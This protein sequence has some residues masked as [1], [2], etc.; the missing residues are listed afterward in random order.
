MKKVLMLSF[1]TLSSCVTS[2]EFIQTRRAENYPQK[3]I[4]SAQASANNKPS[5]APAVS[6]VKNTIQTGSSKVETET[7]TPLSSAAVIPV[8]TVVLPAQ[9]VTT[10]NQTAPV[11]SFFGQPTKE[12]QKLKSTDSYPVDSKKIGAI[13]PLTGKNA[14]V[15]Q[16]AL[17]ALRLGLGLNESNPSLS[18]ALYDSQGKPELAAAGVQKLLKE[19]GVI[20]IFGGLGAKEALAIAEKSDFYEVPFFSFSQKSGL[21]ESFDYTFRNAV[22]A[23]MQVDKLAEFAFQ[24]LSIR[25]FAI[26]YPNDAYGVEF[27][28]KFWDQVLARG[29]VVAAA[30]VYDPKSSDLNGPVQKMVGTFYNEDRPDEVKAKLKGLKEKKAKQAAAGIKKNSRE[31]EVAENILEPIVDFDAIFIPDSGRALGQAMAFLKSNDIQ[32]LTYLGTNLWNTPDLIRRAGTHNQHLF[33]VDTE[34]S[35]TENTD[36]DFYKKYFALNQEEPQLLEAQTY[37]AA[38]IVR[39]QISMGATGR[40]SLTA[41]LRSLGRRNGAYSE[42][43]MNNNKELERDLTIL[44]VDQGSLKKY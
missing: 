42:I 4:P 20:A 27:A 10:T 12:Q 5:E 15:G 35:I 7:A 1:F 18:L 37:E 43:R 19:H 33:F 8:E 29:G 23:E 34:S 17:A 16:R 11:T 3:P 21:T 28:N 38:K 44:T 31:S 9:T 30:Q 13:L 14:G 40:E 39:E 22:T 41:Q 32:N 24:K 25:R 36:S 6:S 26:L 2:T